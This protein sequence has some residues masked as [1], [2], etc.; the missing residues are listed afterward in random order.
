MRATD[1]PWFTSG[2]IRPAPLP[3]SPLLAGTRVKQHDVHATKHADQ[4]MLGVSGCFRQKVRLPDRK[5]CMPRSRNAREA[6]A[7][8]S[9]TQTTAVTNQGHLVG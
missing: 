7:Q 9:I 4:Q 6:S 3:E 8:P 5:R 1:S 2:Q